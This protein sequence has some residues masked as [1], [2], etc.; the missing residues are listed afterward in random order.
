M[1]KNKIALEPGTDLAKLLNI[2]IIHFD[3]NK[4]IILPDA[5]VELEKLLAVLNEFPEMHI[6]IRSHTDSRGSDS[7]NQTI[8]ESRAKSTLEYLVSKGIKRQRL[9][10][11][12]LGESELINGCSNGVPCS[13][14]EHQQN[15]RSEFIVLE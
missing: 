4:S 14:E 1:Q 9:V 12:G 11:A 2:P 5:K 7:H 3:F 15:R 6:T 10:S 13:E 8:S